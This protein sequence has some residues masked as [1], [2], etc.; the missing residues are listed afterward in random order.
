MQTFLENSG[1]DFAF[2]AKCYACSEAA[3]PEVRFV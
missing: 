3:A 2:A 1:G